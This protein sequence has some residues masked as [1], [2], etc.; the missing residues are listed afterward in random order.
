MFPESPSRFIENTTDYLFWKKSST[1]I[2]A[3]LLR[4]ASPFGTLPLATTYMLK[5]LYA[6]DFRT[7][8]IK[9]LYLY[10]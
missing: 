2:R 1:T 8:G 7:L 5:P 3:Y 4:Y 9:R 10:S 6:I